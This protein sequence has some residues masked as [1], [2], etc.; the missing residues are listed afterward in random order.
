[1]GTCDTKHKPS[2]SQRE[3]TG[4]DGRESHAALT[5]YRCQSKRLFFL[6]SGSHLRTRSKI[7]LVS[8]HG[9]PRVLPLFQGP[10]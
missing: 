7:N 4:Q 1:M 2:T 3:G 5:M 6:K 10:V 9:P 8:Y